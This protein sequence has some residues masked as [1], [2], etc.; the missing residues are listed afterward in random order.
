MKAARCKS[1][2]LQPEKEESGCAGIARIDFSIDFS[3][4]YIVIEALSH[5]EENSDTVGRGCVYEYQ[6]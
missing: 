6:Q 5:T 1:Q 4:D 3:I 2:K